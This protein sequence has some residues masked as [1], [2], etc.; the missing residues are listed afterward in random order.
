LGGDR[1]VDL[2]FVRFALLGALA[3]VF[4]A[5]PSTA[6]AK[7]YRGRC[8]TGACNLPPSKIVKSASGVSHRRIVHHSRVIPRTRVVNH[9]RLVLHRHTVHHRH[10]TVHKHRLVH[11]LTVLHRMN[12]V[13]R[14][15]VRHRHQYYARHV[16]YPVHTV[17]HRYVQGYNRWCGC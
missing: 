7:D 5:A 16:Y 6:D 13:H 12:M 1:E 8:S 9:N 17:Q 11:K 4:V 10:L 3:L 2:M 14:R 15:E